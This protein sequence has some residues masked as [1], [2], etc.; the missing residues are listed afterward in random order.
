MRLAL[1]R[2]V[3]LGAC[4]LWCLVAGCGGDSPSLPALPAGFANSPDQLLANYFDAYATR[5][6]AALL[7]TIHPSFRMVFDESA[8][9]EL[10]MI[11]R[12]LNA[13]EELQTAF[14][15]FGGLTGRLPDGTVLPAL[16]EIHVILK[17]PV[18]EWAPSAPEDPDFPGLL[19]RRYSVVL[20]ALRG[21]GVQFMIEGQQEFFVASRDSIL[22]GGARAPFFQLVGQRDLIG[23]SK[24]A[25]PVSWGYLN[26]MYLNNQP[27]IPDVA[28]TPAEGLVGGFDLS[29]SGSLD[30]EGALDPLPYRW[31]LAFGTEWSTWRASPDT[32]VVFD[33]NGKY[34]AELQVKDKWGEVEA[35][36]RTISV[37]S[38]ADPFPTTPDAAILALRIGYSSMDVG[39]YRAV[40]HPQYAFILCPLDVRPGGP[41]RFGYADELTVAENMFSGLPFER[42]GD[43]PVPA[44]SSISIATLI[45]VGDWTDVGPDDPDFPNTRR[46]LHYVHVIFSR[47]SANTITASGTQVFYVSA[48]DSLVNGVHK[49]FCQVRGQR[50]LGGGPKGG[51]GDSWGAVKCLYFY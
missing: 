30:P 43:I 21:D 26:L 17:E 8:S 10:G 29:A 31:R 38:L 3:A 13:A 50:D 27:P 37:S 16:V 15:Q 33:Y 7:P 28:V 47:A 4:C 44:I 40:L 23:A 11:G 39:Y 19:G 34:G 22:P 45:R 1:A 32:Q 35:C 36:S 42:P 25:V 14:R 5:S 12:D 51:D 18:G 20:T 2:L 6:Y 48:R 46:G 24:P 41:D 9:V 49:S